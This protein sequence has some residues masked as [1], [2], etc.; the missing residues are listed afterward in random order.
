MIFIGIDI[1]LK[2]G[3]CAL[4]DVAGIDPISMLPMPVTDVLDAY[5]K[6]Q[7][8]IDVRAVLDW[9]A[10]L[11]TPPAKIRVAMEALPAHMDRASSLASLGVSYGLLCGMLLTRG[12]RPKPVAARQWQKEL[13][14]KVPKGETKAFALAKA[15]ELWPDEDFMLGRCRTP[16]DGIV[17]GALIAEFLRRK[18]A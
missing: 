7:S 8:Q 17:D 12:I 15:K 18:G 6:R 13:L 5:G 4:S 11:Q 2:G 1:G 16:H 14:G 9:L 3:L 10:S